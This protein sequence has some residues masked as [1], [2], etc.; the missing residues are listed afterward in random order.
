MSRQNQ[1]KKNV[2]FRPKTESAI[3]QTIAIRKAELNELTQQAREL[4][5]I[6]HILTV[7][8]AH[9]IGAGRIEKD[10]LEY[11]KQ[12]D[13]VFDMLIDDG[14]DDKSLTYTTK[15]LSDKLKAIMGRENWIRFQ[16]NFPLL[17]SYWEDEEKC[18]SG[19]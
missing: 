12:S 3:K 15:V 2:P 11:K 14:T 4:D 6:I 8:A 1:K 9:N 10:L 7:N 18:K 17:K 5:L 19:L 16:K 13:V